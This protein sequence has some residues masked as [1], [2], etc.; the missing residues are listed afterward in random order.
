MIWPDFLAHVPHPVSFC[1]M[2]EMGTSYLPIDNSWKNYIMQAEEMYVKI[3]KELQES[4]M[5]GAENVLQL[6]SEDR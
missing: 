3:S 5:E 2:L 4:L 1:G 6:I